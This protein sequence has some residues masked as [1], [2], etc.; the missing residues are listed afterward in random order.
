MRATKRARTL[1]QALW[2]NI[3]WAERYLAW[4]ESRKAAMR[5]IQCAH[6]RAKKQAIEDRVHS[7]ILSKLEQANHNL[8][9]SINRGI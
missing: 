6:R 1:S 8:Y 3:E 2:Y 5:Q 9:L 4:K 7:Q